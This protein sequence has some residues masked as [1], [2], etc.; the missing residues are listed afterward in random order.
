MCQAVL[1]DRGLDLLLFRS[2]FSLSLFGFL[3]A[4]NYVFKGNR[5]SGCFFDYLYLHFLIFN[6]IRIFLPSELRYVFR[7]KKAVSGSVIQIYRC[8][9]LSTFSGVLQ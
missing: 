2:S 1:I 9:G 3:G 4:S 8:G 5:L 7:E 6:V